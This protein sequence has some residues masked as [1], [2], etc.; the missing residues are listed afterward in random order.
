MPDPKANARAVV[1]AG[2]ISATPIEATEKAA[3]AGAALYRVVQHSQPPLNLEAEEFRYFAISPTDAI[4]LPSAGEGSFCR[5]D[6]RRR[7]RR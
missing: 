1:L 5:D 6:H 4:P 2:T 3:R 7:G